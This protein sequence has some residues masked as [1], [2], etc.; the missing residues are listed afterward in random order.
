MVLQSPP[1]IARSSADINQQQQ[2]QQ[3]RNAKQT[4]GAKEKSQREA[5]KTDGK[6]K[7]PLNEQEEQLSEEQTYRPID[8]TILDESG[9][10]GRTL[11]ASFVACDTNLTHILLNDLK[12]PIGLQTSALM[13][14]NDVIAITYR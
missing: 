3:P 12:T 9:A 13:R 8:I 10:T 4:F 11:A 14:L 2:Q 1:S 6:Q 5:Y 7:S